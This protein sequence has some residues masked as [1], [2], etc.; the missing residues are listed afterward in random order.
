V[1]VDAWVSLNG[2]PA[3]RLI[4]PTVDL[5][6]EPLDLWPDEWILSPDSPESPD[7]PDDQVMTMRRATTR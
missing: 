7:S 3:R 2:R 6:A 5:A 4:D 1:R